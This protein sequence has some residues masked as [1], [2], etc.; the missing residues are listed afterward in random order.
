MEA[1]DFAEVADQVRFLART[2]DDQSLL[3]R[4]PLF[5][6]P[7]ASRQSSVPVA[8]TGERLRAGTF[9]GIPERRFP[10]CRLSSE[11]F[12]CSYPTSP[13][14]TAASPANDPRALRIDGVTHPTFRS[15]FMPRP[16]LLAPLLL[17]LVVP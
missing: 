3:P 5:Y 1:R 16:S 8:K 15:P 10:V 9:E 4:T 13:R 17:V 6:Q 7:A 12:P 11:V 2:L 14:S